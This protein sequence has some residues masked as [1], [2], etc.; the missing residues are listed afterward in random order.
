PDAV[1]VAVPTK[2][3]AEIGGYLLEN[4]IHVFSEK[5]F[6]LAVNEGGRLVELAKD[7]ELVTQVGYHN[8]FIGTFNEAKKIVQN[9]DIGEVLHFT[10]EAYG[11][12][13]VRE[14][15]NNWRADPSQG[16]GCLMD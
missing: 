8:K 6:C 3:H 15:Q 7:K 2:F 4:G 13:V 16:G 1:F 10:G 9:G 12:V 11:P 14:K 5:P